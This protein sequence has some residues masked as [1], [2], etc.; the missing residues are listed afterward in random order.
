MGSG[1]QAQSRI[2]PAPLIMLGTLANNT[3]AYLLYL[4]YGAAFL[5]LGVSIVAKDKKGSSLVIAEN[6][7][8]LAAFAFLHGFCEWLEL[9]HL[10]DAERISTGQFSFVK[11][12]MLASNVVSYFCLLLFGV[13]ITA[14]IPRCPRWVKALPGC[15]LLLW[16]LYLVWPGADEYRL[17]LNVQLMRD[18]KKAGRIFFGMPG[19]MLTA[20]GLIVHSRQVRSL[21]SSAAANLFCAGA[22]F[23]VFGALVLLPPPGLVFSA[24]TLP[25]VMLRGICA[26]FISY[27]VSAGLGIFDIEKRKRYE[28]QT[29]R[30]VQAEKLASLGQLAA[31]IAHEI[32]NP[33]ACASLVIERLRKK[34]SG[35]DCRLKDM[36]EILDTAEK[37][38]DRA[39]VI[40]RELLQ[41]SRKG[42]STPVPVDVNRLVDGALLLMNYKLKECTVTKELSPVPPVLGDPGKLEQVFINALSNS[43]DAMPGGGTIAVRTSSN[44]DSVVIRICD[45]GTG[46][47]PEDLGSVF[48][49][50]FTTKEIG[51]GTGLGL[52]VSYGIIA[53]H[54][55][56]IDIE[57]KKGTGTS[58]TVRLPAGCT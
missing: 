44:G 36:L 22:S 17:V 19:S 16:V 18:A 47:D 28:C 27:F 33:L 58:V 48:D 42:D 52:Y 57:S 6:L 37:N 15:L 1:G 35:K 8:L 30:L 46:I 10:L 11:G 34:L 53:Q 12:G 49:P 56:E 38:I 43:A 45:D 50:F 55:G 25:A 21:D 9:G 39:S 3:A 31:G 41:F 51:Q 24:I 2:G 14:K 5:Y 4:F 23:V 40:A 26:V 7:R 13:G 29:R 54:K 20:L 32:N